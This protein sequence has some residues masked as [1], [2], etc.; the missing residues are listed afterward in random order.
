MNE[1]TVL[2]NLLIGKVIV[3]A[4]LGP[5]STVLVF[6]DGTRFV[7]EKTFEGLNQ[8]TLFGPEGETIALAVLG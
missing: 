1:R 2:E 3:R 8:A 5:G 6:T 4:E 7:R